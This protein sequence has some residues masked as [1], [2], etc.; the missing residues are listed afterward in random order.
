MNSE[1]LT[2]I[3]ALILLLPLAAAVVLIFFGRRLP[4][5]GDW[6]AIGVMAVCFVLSLVLFKAVIV[7]E[8]ANPETYARWSFP[9]ITLGGVTL[10]M[11][12]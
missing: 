10:S 4:R 11:A 3:P 1:L 5:Q 7:D 12:S 8:G 2:T 9:W 6:L